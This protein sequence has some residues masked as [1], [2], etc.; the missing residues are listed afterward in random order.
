MKP[1]H[2]FSGPVLIV[3]E[4]G[5][6]HEGDFEVAQRLVRQAARAGVDAVKFQ[7]FKAR[8]LSSQADTERFQRLTSFELGEEQFAAL[9]QQAR[10]LGLLFMST[11]FDLASA[12]FLEPLVDAYKIA[13]GDNN[14]RALVER[15][16]DTG[17]P[18]IV[19]SGLVELDWMRHLE[20]L[21]KGR[22]KAKGVTQTLAILHCVCSYPVPPEEANLSAIPALANDLDCVIG[23]S[24]HTL[25]LEACLAAVSLGARII[26]KHF[27][28]DHNYSAFR[29]HQLSADPDEMT[30]LVQSI[31]K[32]EI[33]V[34]GPQA[35]AIQPGEKTLQ[36]AA[37]RSIVAARA[38]AA[39]HRLEFAD[40]TWIRPGGGLSPGQESELVGRRVNRDFQFGEQIQLRDLQG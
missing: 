9:A 22:W 14:F 4:I 32:I 34:G 21:I 5:N 19:S 12:E 20:T 30:R 10:D 27:T 35:K 18:L 31:R 11:P 6:N 28:L 15:V 8:Y 13:S 3:A 17:K 23:Y 16:A 25:G 39:G 37:R 33:M 26:E 38:L 2:L 36:T 24:D 40:L 1:G 29:D 7:T